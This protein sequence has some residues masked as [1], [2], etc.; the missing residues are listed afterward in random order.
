MVHLA[1]QTATNLATHGFE[2]AALQIDERI[3]PTILA[4]SLFGRQA[5][6]LAPVAL[7][8]AVTIPATRL[9]WPHWISAMAICHANKCSKWNIFAIWKKRRV[10][11]RFRRVKG[12]PKLYPARTDKRNKRY[13]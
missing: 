2:L 4:A 1:G 8:F 12:G 13:A 3:T 11:I 10:T 6:R 9:L 5:M 7:I